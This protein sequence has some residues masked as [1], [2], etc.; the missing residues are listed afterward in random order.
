M[1]D[2]SVVVPYQTAE[3][4]KFIQLDQSTYP[5]VSVVRSYYPD[6]SQAFPENYNTQPVS[7]VDIYPKY[8]V[9]S[10]ITNPDDISVSLSAGQVNV[11]LD[12]IEALITD[13]KKLLEE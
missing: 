11:E 7:S 1:S 4:S 3:Y 5:A 6:Q 9:L 10:Y 12:E 8:G 2:S 13:V